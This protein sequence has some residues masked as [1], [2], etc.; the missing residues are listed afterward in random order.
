MQYRQT[1]LFPS[2]VLFT[3]AVY[4]HVTVTCLTHDTTHVYL[5]STQTST[6]PHGKYKL[7]F[8]KFMVLVTVAV[9]KT[10]KEVIWT[11]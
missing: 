7:K 10:I 2:R 4:C 1:P 9:C 8:T 6:G 5:T 3:D 11:L